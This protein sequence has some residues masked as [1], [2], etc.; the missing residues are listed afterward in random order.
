MANDCTDEMSVIVHVTPT[1]W[2]ANSYIA[3]FN[4]ST[5]TTTTKDSWGIYMDAN[6]QINAFVSAFPGAT[7]QTTYAELKS[8]TKLPIDGTPTSIILTVDTQLH[9]GNV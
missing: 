8:T 7:H 6:G 5:D 4:V 3:S 1:S 9:S 2:G